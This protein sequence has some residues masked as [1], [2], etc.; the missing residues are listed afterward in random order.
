M[1]TWYRIIPMRNFQH[2]NL[3]YKSFYSVKI[4]SSTVAILWRTPS[5]CSL[6]CVLSS[7]L[8]SSMKMRRG[9]KVKPWNTGRR[10]RERNRYAGYKERFLKLVYEQKCSRFIWRGG[11][12]FTCNR[13]ILPYM[14]TYV[15]IVCLTHSSQWENFRLFHKLCPIRICIKVVVI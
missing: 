8:I 4:S 15:F 5:K 13:G 1:L 11:G 2:D 3:S 9:G 7:R 10:K 14:Y 6:V 12:P